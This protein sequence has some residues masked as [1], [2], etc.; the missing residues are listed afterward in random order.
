[1]PNK[2][3]NGKKMLD[4]IFPT[5][6]DFYQMLV[7][8]TE[9]TY[10]GVA[11]FQKWL[12]NG[13]MSEVQS[14]VLMEEQLD[15]L[16][17]ELQHKLHE[18]FSTPFDREEIYSISRQMDYIMNHAVLTAKQMRAYGVPPDQASKEMTKQLVLGMGHMAAAMKFLQENDKK[19]DD[20]VADMRVCQRQI[21]DLYI[22]AMGDLFHQND[23]IFVMKRAEIYH[24]L[25]ETG[26]NLRTCID[27]F[28][29]ILVGIL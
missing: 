8:Q 3:G 11:E 14:L 16:R 17:Y 20:L 29:R 26:H 6:Y 24:N 2:N 18:A 23:L 28:H 4:R 22:E 7:D 27:L 19:A 12:E 9:Q 5:E 1:M 15:D 25:M 13:H 21:E 10:R